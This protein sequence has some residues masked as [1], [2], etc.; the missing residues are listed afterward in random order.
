M[1]T[2][3]QCENKKKI[4]CYPSELFKMR[5]LLFHHRSSKALQITFKQ[6][7]GLGRYPKLTQINISTLIST[8]FISCCVAGGRNTW[9]APV[10]FLH[11]DSIQS[12]M[13]IPCFSFKTTWTEHQSR[14]KHWNHFYK[15]HISNLLWLQ[16]ITFSRIRTWSVAQCRH[17]ESLI[18]FIALT[19]FRCAWRFQMLCVLVRNVL[20]T[21]K[22]NPSVTAP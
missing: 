17:R 8:S 7:A 5:K 14:I 4:N 19:I 16:R 9:A 22:Q 13:Q 21:N 1:S 6:A 2:V 12:F 11:L 15:H 3:F 10:T 20:K 18:S